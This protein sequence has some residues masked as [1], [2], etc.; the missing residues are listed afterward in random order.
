[1][2]IPIFSNSVVTKLYNDIDKNKDLYMTGFKP[3]FFQNMV[4][5]WVPNTEMSENL[6]EKLILDATL[7]G[8]QLDSRNSIIMYNE[9]NNLTP[10]QARDERIWCALSHQFFRKYAIFRHFKSADSSSTDK[11]ADKIKRHFFTRSG[12]F[13]GTERDNVASRLW[14]NGY[15]VRNC[16]EEG[17]FESLVEV[18]C[19]NTDLRAQIVERP[20]IFQIPN[21]TLAVLLFL[22]EKR[23]AGKVLPR[24]EYRSW[25]RLINFGGGQ[26]MYAAMDSSQLKELFEGYFKEIENR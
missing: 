9:L 13:R 2:Q 23:E 8:G 21:V 1:M 20:G 5:N 11:D 6:S 24:E 14:W 16:C 10:Y 4:Q 17:D 7:S 26:K 25:F 15:I 18:L 19:E 12:G 22:R 3:N